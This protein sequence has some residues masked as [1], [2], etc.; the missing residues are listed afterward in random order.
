VRATI[1]S[2]R[3]ELEAEMQDAKTQLADALAAQVAAVADRDAAAEL[4]RALRHAMVALPAAEPLAHAVAQ[5]IG[6]CDAAAYDAAGTV[7]RAAGQV[8][9]IR[10]RIADLELASRQLDQL[11]LSPGEAH[12]AE[13]ETIDAE[14]G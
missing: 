2:W 13:Q 1:E 9:A 3:D 5:R 12:D 14:A 8:A 10:V 7:L 6:R 4:H 11:L